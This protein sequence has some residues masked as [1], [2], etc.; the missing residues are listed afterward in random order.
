MLQTEERSEGTPLCFC[1]KG[2]GVDLS[3]MGCEAVPDQTS[4]YGRRIAF[5]GFAAGARQI[6]GKPTPTPF[7]Q[8]QKRKSASQ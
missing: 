4:P 5:P 3:T 1:P 6:V 7:G 8:I 2:V